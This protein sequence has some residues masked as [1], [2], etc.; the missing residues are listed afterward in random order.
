MTERV[1]SVNHIAKNNQLLTDIDRSI[2]NYHRLGKFSHRIVANEKARHMHPCM[3]GCNAG[4]HGATVPPCRLAYGPGVKPT[5][6]APCTIV[7]ARGKMVPARSQ[8]LLTTWFKK[9]GLLSARTDTTVGKCA[10]CVT[11]QAKMLGRKVLRGYTAAKQA[12]TWFLG[13]LDMLARNL[14]NTGKGRSS[15]DNCYNTN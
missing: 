12:V 4:C 5:M 14:R 3:P 8:G 9:R 10:A 11:Q 6:H 2:A 15:G 1:K 13:G 7:P